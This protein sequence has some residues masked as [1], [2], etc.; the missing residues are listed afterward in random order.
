MQTVV[1]SMNLG[2]VVRDSKKTSSLLPIA[3]SQKNILVSEAKAVKAAF[4]VKNKEVQQ[5]WV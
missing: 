5:W 3:N 1:W 4:S 2:S